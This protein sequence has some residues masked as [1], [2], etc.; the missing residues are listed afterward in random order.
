MSVSII[1]AVLRRM[2]NDAVRCG[3]NLSVPKTKWRK[4]TRKETEEGGLH[5]EDEFT[6]AVKFVRN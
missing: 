2:S 3:L 1:A 4:A 6:Q 5:L